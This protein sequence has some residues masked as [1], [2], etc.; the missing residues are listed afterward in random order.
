MCIP[1]PGVG[2]GWICI[3]LAPTPGGDGRDD[4]GWTISATATGSPGATYGFTLG[5][6]S[7]KVTVSLTGLSRDMDCR[8]HENPAPVSGGAVPRSARVH[9]CPDNF[10]TWDE[11]WSGVLGAGAHS[12]RVYPFQRR[13]TGDYTITVSGDGA[14]GF[15]GESASPPPPATNPPSNPSNP[16]GPSTPSPPSNPSPPSS[17][18]SLPSIPDFELPSGGSVDTTFPAATDG[19]PPYVYNV[20]GLPPGISFS[21]STRRAAG[22]LPSVTADIGYNVTYSVTD[23]ASGSA[24][25]SFVATVLAPPPPSAPQLSGSVSGRT[26]TLRWTEP[27]GGGITRYQLQTRASSAHSWRFSGAGAPS[28]T[29]NIAPTARS[30]SVVTPWTLYRQYQVRATN[31]FGDGPWSN[32]VEL[33]TPA[34]PPP[35]PPPP[36]RLSLPSIPNFRLP[37]AGVVNTTFPAATGGS[38]AYSYSVSGLPPGITFYPSTRGASGTLPTVSSDTTYTVTYT[39]TDSAN[40][41]ASVS[42]TATVVP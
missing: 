27:S 23:N 4:N 36:P 37:S 22:T 12:V 31:A 25:V 3:P 32:M 20:S 33:T 1:T 11:T 17:S 2:I 30:W 6:A 9:R 40:A 29:S 24:S 42:F 19:T 7:Q 8:I 41:T 16:S 39:V 35:P 15:I 21:G 5:G 10:G 28:P 13:R 18:L 34:A 14:G 26:Q 38:P